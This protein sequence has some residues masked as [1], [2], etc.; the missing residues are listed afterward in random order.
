VETV[1]LHSLRTLEVIYGISQ[2]AYNDRW[3]LFQEVFEEVEH[4][5][6]LFLVCLLHDIGKGYRGDHAQKGAELIPGIL[7]RLG[8]DGDALEEIPFLVR[9]HLLMVNISQRRDL[10]EERTSIQV[11]QAVQ[12]VEQLRL[13][14]L[15]T[16]ADSMA[17]GPM[18]GSDWK[19][20][21][22]IELFFKVRRILERGTLASPDATK[23]MEKTRREVVRA[24]RPRF[25]EKHILDLMD[26]VSTRYFLNNPVEDMVRHFQLALTMEEQRLSWTLEKLKDAPVTRVVLCT[27]D[28][29]GL[30][31]K[32]VGVFTLNNIKVLSGNIFTLKNGLAF[33][34][35]D[36]TNPLDPYREEERWQRIF[37]DA[38][39]AIEDR[40]PLDELINKKE[41]T[42]LSGSIGH[43]SPVKRVRIDNEASDFFTIIEVSGGSR[44]SLL[45]DLA[46]G[47]HSIGLDIRFARVTSDK[48]RTMGVFYV[49]DV[50]GQKIYEDTILEETRDVLL[51]VIA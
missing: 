42:V 36:V 18:A 19:I 3:P 34:T 21:L 41:R 48:E 10:N 31:S 20:M 14:F 12:G 15:L 4:P 1:D 37:N 2:G 44:T 6:W 5:D 33:D 47:I 13:L 49:R 17:T 22:L 24:L 40:L 32:M 26:Q 25:S 27:H 9:N 35:Y 51:S 39:S 45:Y 7:K 50:N 38:I 29:P 11:A 28:K 16:V 30:F 8:I 46:K 23:R 43:I